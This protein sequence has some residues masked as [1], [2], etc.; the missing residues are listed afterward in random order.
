MAEVEEV[1][2]SK[3]VF[4]SEIA[5]LVL[6]TVYYLYNKFFAFRIAK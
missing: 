6:N 2:W 5:E 4:P 3:D 1:M